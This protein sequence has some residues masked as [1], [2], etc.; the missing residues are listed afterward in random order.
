MDVSGDYSTM[1]AS[2]AS[3]L[4]SGQLISQISVAV[5]KQ[6]QDQ[7]QQQADMLIQ[8]INQTPRPSLDGTGQIID[9]Y[10]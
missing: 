2:T 8:M 6:I 4:K 7:Q 3:E 1:M 5:F 10:A 9:I